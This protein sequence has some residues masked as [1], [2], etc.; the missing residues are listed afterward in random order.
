MARLCVQCGALALV[1]NGTRAAMLHTALVAVQYCYITTLLLGRGFFTLG[2]WIFTVPCSF[3]S[4]VSI[5]YE[6]L[7]N[8]KKSENTCPRIELGSRSPMANSKSTAPSGAAH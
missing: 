1:P 4:N 2:H 3:S 8:N 6:L 7:T 5:H